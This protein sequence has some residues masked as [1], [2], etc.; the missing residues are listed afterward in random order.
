MTGRLVEIRRYVAFPGRRAELADIMDR[1][2]IP[3]VRA[4]G[5]EV[6]GSLLVEDDDDAYIWIR[7]FHDESDRE[8]AY[9]A[10]YQDPEWIDTIGPAVKELMDVE[11]AVITTATTTA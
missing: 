1:V 4:R 10:I 2:V 5:V 11:R 8:R 7:A 9:A 3:F 6:T